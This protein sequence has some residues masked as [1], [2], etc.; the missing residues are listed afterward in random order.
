M[1][2]TVTLD[3]KRLDQLA[4]DIPGGADR[5]VGAIAFDLE[6]DIKNSFNTGP[7]GREYVRAGG[8]VHVASAEPGPP[9]VDYGTLRASIKASRISNA[10]WQVIAGTEYAEF[11]EYGT[12][13]MGARPF[14]SPAVFRVKQRITERFKGLI[15]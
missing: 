6:A 12:P 5:I 13:R 14:F 4:R 1:T 2:I 15:K 10:L 8:R 7:A 9:A 3:T 11:L